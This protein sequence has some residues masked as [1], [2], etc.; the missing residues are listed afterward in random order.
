MSVALNNIQ[1]S[2]PLP[3]VSKVNFGKGFSS[4]TLKQAWNNDVDQV[5]IEGI[6][7]QHRHFLV[8]SEKDWW[9]PNENIGQS[10]NL[11]YEMFKNY[12]DKP[13]KEM[14]FW[15]RWSCRMLWSYQAMTR[16]SNTKMTQGISDG[17]AYPHQGRPSCSEHAILRIQNKGKTFGGFVQSL[18]EI[19]RYNLNC[20]VTGIS[21]KLK[22]DAIGAK[23]YLKTQA[24]EN[25]QA[26]SANQFGI[27][28]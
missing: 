20:A 25:K 28:G 13:F 12:G 16:K 11:R 8:G 6:K 10:K 23:K 15:Q 4:V 21:G 9:K 7:P 2:Q 1:Y 17:C 27:A 18:A 26:I 22:F 14:R 5:E 24:A 3:P 19:F